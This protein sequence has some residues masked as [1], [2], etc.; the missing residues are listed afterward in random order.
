MFDLILSSHRTLDLLNVPF[1]ADFLAK[2]LYAFIYCPM[3]AIFPTYPTLYDLIALI[4][5]FEDPM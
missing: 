1:Y 3:R 4:I 5:F 2:T